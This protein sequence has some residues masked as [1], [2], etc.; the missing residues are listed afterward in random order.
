MTKR[1]SPSRRQF[2]R[3]LAAGTCGAACHQIVRP[4]GMVAYAL[5][6]SGRVRNFIEIFFYGG[7]CSYGLF[8][9]HNAGAQTRYPTLYRTPAQAASI[10][11]PDQSLHQAFT[12]FVAEANAAGPHIAL[13]VGTG[14]MNARGQ[15]SRSH[16]E[17]QI[18]NERVSL[19]Y[20]ISNS[21]GVG[22]AIAQ[23]I[24]HPYSLISF[25]GASEFAQGGA[26]T[27]RSIS[28]LSN[29]G[30]PTFGQDMHFRYLDGLAKLHQAPAST[31]AQNYV[32]SSITGME[33]N[34]ATLT[35]L[36]SINPQFG[37]PNSGI[38][39]T[40][41]DITRLITARLGNVYFVPY[42]GFDTHSGQAGQHQDLLSTLNA[43]LVPLVRNLKALPGHALPTA[44]DETVVVTRTDFGRTFENNAAGTDHGLAH[45]QMIF[46][47]AVRGGVYGDPPDV[48]RYQNE[49]GGYQ[50]PGWVQ[51]SAGQPTK[52]IVLQGM[53]LSNIPFPEYVGNRYAPLGFLL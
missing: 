38:G 37:F 15:F 20:T 31:D 11:H 13:I 46:G 30:R 36:S 29:A 23:D 7:Y 25:G 32:H 49:R 35:S 34:I 41:R 1:T 53:G 45:T 51:F 12:T 43:A 22:A 9:Q 24:G 50:G 27:G 4:H 21:I 19:D 8:P 47:G 26:I 28:S 39:N 16:D 33:Q 14:A 40:L 44:W 5:P 17:A 42:G 3:M 10:G 2:L 48:A 52:E 6:P 18:A